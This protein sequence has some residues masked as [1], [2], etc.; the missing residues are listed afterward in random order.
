ML[1]FLAKVGLSVGLECINGC[2]IIRNWCQFINMNINDDRQALLRDIRYLYLCA[3]D[4]ANKEL[5]TAVFFKCLKIM[6]QG[7]P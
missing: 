6:S 1:P 5:L 7:I 3:D 4:D 2:A